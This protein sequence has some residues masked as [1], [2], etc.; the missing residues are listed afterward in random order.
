[1]SNFAIFDKSHLAKLIEPFLPG[2]TAHITPIK[3]Q[4]VTPDLFL[5]MFRTTGKDNEDY[6]FVSLETDHIEGPEKIVSLMK[7]WANADVREILFPE[8]IDEDSEE[9]PSVISADPYKAF[10][11]MIEKPQKYGYWSDHVVIEDVSELD[12]K[13][14]AFSDTDRQSARKLFEEY[15]NNITMAVYKTEEGMFEMF[16]IQKNNAE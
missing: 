6:F 12:E 9:E 13:M 8:G 4:A 11:I 16:Y 7:S 10:M 14:T 1:M 3:Y 15:D 2:A 5:F